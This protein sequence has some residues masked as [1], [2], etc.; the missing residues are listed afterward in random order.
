MLEVN[1]IDVFYGPL[2]VLWN[3]SVKVLKGET[4]G[5]FGSNGHGKTTLLKTIS[6]LLV[7]SKGVIKFDGKEINNKPPHEIVKL[8]IVHVM[9]GRHLFPDMSVIEN[10]K[11]GAYVSDAWKRRHDN[12]EKVFRIFPVLKERRNQRAGT[13]S[14][15][16]R[17]MV[18]IGRGLMSNAKLLMLDEPSLGLA[19]NLV[20]EISKK[21]QDIK[22]TGIDV[23]LVDQNVGLIEALSDRMYLIEN[24]RVMVE[25][26]KEDMQKNEYVRKAYLGEIAG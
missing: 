12:L 14:G 8:G 19:P 11:L 13:L 18:A 5:I 25:G 26:K 22:K 9:Q 23:I 15:G 24:G 7:P 3:I 6:G 1:G 21:I 20:Q 2:Q 4:I 16:E 10:L 17:Q